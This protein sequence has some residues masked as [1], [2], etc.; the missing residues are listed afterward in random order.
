[1]FLEGFPWDIVQ[2]ER[3]GVENT[4]FC[5]HNTNIHNKKLYIAEGVAV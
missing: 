3:Q 4:Y 5:F 2:R 1:M